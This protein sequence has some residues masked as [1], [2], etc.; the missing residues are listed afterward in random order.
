M[1]AGSGFHPL[2]NLGAA[3]EPTFTTPTAIAVDQSTNDVLVID[4]QA[5]TL[6]RFHGDGTPA[7]FSALD[8]TN[9]IDGKPGEADATPFEEINFGFSAAEM[10]IA[11]D[12]SGGATDGNI[13]VTTAFSTIL[14]FSSSGEFIGEL[15]HYDEGPAAEGPEAEFILVSGVAVGPSGDLYVAEGFL[16]SIHKYEPAGSVPVA[17]DNTA[18]FSMTQPAALAA[19][20][21]PSAGFIF[22]TEAPGEAGSSNR[23]L[24]LNAET[25]AEQYVVS[26][27]PNTTISLDPISGNLYAARGEE[28]IELNVAGP[29]EAAEIS[30]TELASASRG[31]AV[32]AATGNVYAT[33]NGFAKVE[34]FAPG[35]ISSFEL[36]IEKTGTGQG[37]VTSEPPGI[38]CGAKCSAEF[39]EGMEVELQATAAP[40]SKFTGWSAIAGDPGSCTGPPRLAR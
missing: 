28:F 32:N 2:E 36:G 1:F 8:N 16:D 18:N 35:L 22:A 13:Y 10:Q 24:K 25:G 3:N 40:N 34:V 11:V 39:G 9:V 23:V 4:A 17:A 15:N 12:D 21:G 29:K 33:R 27:E 37:T 5:R 14:V 7:N 20:S 38:N 19:G 6:S 30:A 31:V 26:S